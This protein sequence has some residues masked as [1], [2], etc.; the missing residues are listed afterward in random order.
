MDDIGRL[1]QL[2][3][4][5]Y[6][7]L[8]IVTYEEQY[9]LEI[10]RQTALSLDRDVWIWSVGNGVRDGLIADSPIIADT[11]T[12]ASGLRN[13]AMTK[14]GSICIAL[15]LAEHLKAGLAQRAFRDL[16]QHFEKNGSTLVMIDSEDNLRI[17][18]NCNPL[19]ARPCAASIARNRLKSES[20]E[21]AW[22][23]SSA[24]SVG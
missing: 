5:G 19:S 3:T 22:I 9:A 16:I 14:E 17:V 23:R 18:R 20:R 15:D 13:L 1:S 6:A 2:I 11:E 7:C 10:V 8:S 24:I 4:S 21:R 12:P